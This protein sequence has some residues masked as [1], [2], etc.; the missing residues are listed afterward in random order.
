MSSFFEMGG[1]EEADRA[2]PQRI[3]T[4]DNYPFLVDGSGAT[5]GG[6]AGSKG[7]GPQKTQGN[8]GGSKE[9]RLAYAQQLLQNTSE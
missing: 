9:E 2:S 8:P 3:L 7:A 1:V 6:A 5:G 4:L